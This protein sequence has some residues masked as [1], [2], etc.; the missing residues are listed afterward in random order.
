LGSQKS[1]LFTFGAV[2]RVDT[3]EAGELTRV[4]FSQIYACDKFA[5][6]GG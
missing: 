3:D 6:V 5:I 2:L 1:P 4:E